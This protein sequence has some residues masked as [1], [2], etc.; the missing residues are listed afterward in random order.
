MPGPVSSRLYRHRGTLPSTARSGVGAQRRRAHQPRAMRLLAVCAALLVLVGGGVA[1]AAPAAHPG[2]L[3]TTTVTSHRV[4]GATDD[5]RSSTQL[6]VDGTDPPGA[7]DPWRYVP[8]LGA[9]ELV[10]GFEP[11]AERWGAGHRGVDLAAAIGQPVR[12]PG[13]GTVT[14][15]GSVA[16]RGVVTVAHPDGLRSSLEPVD[17]SVAVGDEVAAGQ[18]IG[19]IESA[20]GHCAPSACL[21]WGVRDGDTYI[22]PLRLLRTGPTVLLP[23]P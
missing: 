14:F 18:E 15:A 5:G 10:R 2:A 7:T 9:L 4:V 19:E 6:V 3:D 21:H 20:A 1:A 8:P 13:P 16:G 11:P 23:G 12:A 22:N 17:A